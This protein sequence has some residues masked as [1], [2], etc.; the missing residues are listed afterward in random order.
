MKLTKQHLKQI[1]SET[2]DELQIGPVSGHPSDQGT[3][4]ASHMTPEEFAEKYDL[5]VEIRPEDKMKVIYHWDDDAWRIKASDVPSHWD[6]EN[7]GQPEKRVFE[8]NEYE[9]GY[10]NETY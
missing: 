7:A 6:S 3:S 5:E 9:E 8:T 4:A 2:I 10:Q 1:I